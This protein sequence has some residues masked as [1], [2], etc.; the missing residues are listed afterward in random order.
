MLRPFNA[1][2]IRGMSVLERISYLLGLLF[3]VLKWVN[4]SP[5]GS[6]PW[7]VILGPWWVW[8]ALQPIY[9]LFLDKFVN[10]YDFDK[11]EGIPP[12][13]PVVAGWFVFALIWLAIPYVIYGITSL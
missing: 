6:W 11:G 9:T 3:L 12:T 1:V 8:F 4:V 5:L 2:F 13:K 10:R 7:W